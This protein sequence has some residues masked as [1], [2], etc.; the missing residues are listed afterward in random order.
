MKPTPEYFENYEFHK[1]LKENAW[2]VPKH[3]Y[4]QQRDWTCSIAMLRTI[5]SSIVDLESEDE[6]VRKHELVPGPHYSQEIKEKGIL[7]NRNLEVYYGCDHI[8][9]DMSDIIELLK[10]GFYVGI[11]SMINYDHWVVILGY[12]KLGDYDDDMISYFCPYFSE[13]RMAHFSE[14]VEMWMSGNYAENK[15]VHDFIAVKG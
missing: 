5:T 4:R 1:L 3:F 2:N 13:V 10:Q 8:D 11:N 6:I 7:E 12:S 15:I 14:F 9:F